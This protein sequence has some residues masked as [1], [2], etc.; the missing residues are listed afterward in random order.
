MSP[1]ADW[2]DPR[3][4]PRPISPWWLF[5]IIAVLAVVIAALL[6][7]GYSGLPDNPIV[8]TSD[9]PGAHVFVGRE[10]VGVTPLRMSNRYAPRARLPITV[11]RP[12]FYPW[13]GMITG[14][15]KEHFA[16]NLDREPRNVGRSGGP[17]VE[18]PGVPP[19]AR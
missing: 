5:G 11:V 3:S 16:L 19:R 10:H 13:H 8:V 7:H 18:L 6:F 12:G 4:G 15:Q 17:N 1:D 14:G 2:L 9:P